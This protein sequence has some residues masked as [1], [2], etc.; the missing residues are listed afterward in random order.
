MPTTKPRNARLESAASRSKLTPRSKPYWAKVSPNVFLGYRRNATGPGSWSLRCTLDGADWIKKLALADD[1]ERAD[2]RAV[3]TFWQAIDEARKLA[4]RQPGDDAGDDTRP[5]TVAEALDRYEVDLKARGG[6]PYNA[7]RARFHLSALL[8]KPCSMLS[9]GEL[10]KWRDALSAKGLAAATVNRTRT[11]LRAA[12]E[13]AAAHDPHRILNGHAWRV[14]LKGLP[15]ATVANNVIL[16]DTAVR[17]FIAEAYKR[18]RA[19]GLFVDVAAVTGARP[20]QIVRLTVAD[21][22]LAERAAP[23]L[24]MPKSAKGGTSKRAERKLERIPVPVTPELAALLKEASK[25]RASDAPLLTRKDGSAWQYR[26]A[27]LYRDDI[28]AVVAAVGLDPDT[29]T[30]YSL[31]HS[32]IVRHLLANTPIR[33]VAALCDTSVHQIE[34]HYSKHIAR[35]SDEIARKALLKPEPA[36]ANVVALPGRRS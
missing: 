25:R 27:D 13:L 9:A 2:G 19:L 22:D 21:L 15:D 36:A 5:V 23:R 1:Q 16:D 17:A 10:R 14:G 29:T 33:V 6:D 8:S 32:A 31:R 11:A 34:K 28:R 30:L 35:H 4:R 24:L 18:D 26:R 12:L 3:L 7:A 20:S